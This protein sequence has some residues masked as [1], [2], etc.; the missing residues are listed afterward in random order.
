M[1]LCNSPDIFQE[2]MYEL[3]SDLEY[4]RAY[5]DDLLVTSCSTFEEHLQKLDEVFSR[6]SDAGLKVN[7]K[8]SHF[9][10]AEVE[11]LGYWI[12]RH[13]IQP[14]PNKVQAI[15]NIAPPKTRKQLRRFIGMVNYYRDM[16]V[17]RSEILAPLTRLSSEKV[18]FRWTDIEQ[19]AFE[20]IKTIVGR[21][22]LLSYPD[23]SQPFHIHTDASKTQLGSVISQDKKPIAFYSRKLQPAQTRYTTTERE[24]LSIVETLKEFTNILLGQKIIV[25]TDHKNLTCKNFNT[26]RVMRW[27]LILEEYGPEIKYIKGPKN[28]V[29]DAL[30]RLDINDEA[31]E[32]IPV[33]CY[34]LK[35]D[36]L[37]IDSFPVTYYL[38]NREQTKDQKLL[39]RAQKEKHFSLKVFH[40]GGKSTRL[41]CFK[42]KIVVPKGLQSQVIDF[43]HTRLCHPGINRTEETISQHFYWQ[44]MQND[45]TKAVSTCAICQKQKKQTKKY[46]LLPEKE[47]EYLPWDRLCVDLIGPYNIK[48]NVKGIA[49]PTLQCVTMIDPA[50]GW[51]EIAQYDN[52]KA[53]TVANIVEQQWLT[54][55][56]CPY[57]IT[58][59]R[60]SEFIGQDFREMCENDYGIKRKVIS[61]RNPQAN[62]VVERVHQTIGNLI[63]SF[64]L[65]DNP[66]IDEDDP[67][68][69]ILAATAFAVRSTYHTALRATP[70][71][72]VFGRDMILN[73]QHIADW[74]AIK[75]YKQNLIRKNNRI[76]NLKR[77]PYNY[78]VGDQVMI[79]NHRANKYEQP[80]KGPY[81]I[82][83]VN[84]NGTVRLK[85][86][87]VT[88]TVNIR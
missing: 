77:I 78:R 76:E 44:N 83:Q 50:T 11:Y 61:T 57:L 49:I 5:I 69:G 52:K 19:T 16:W 32:L 48:S 15:Q 1:G 59:D 9:A 84:T 85:M 67:W 65:Q 55:Y 8:K 38:L 33:D 25:H 13:G 58:L 54:R 73:V 27:R 56:P 64:E 2:R 28:I 87:A 10:Q 43:Y 35:K 23:F 14:L 31:F 7:A 66:Y 21:E 24:L 60:G 71:Q 62:A 88:D 51:F 18:E 6:L 30:S 39:E 22:V 42:E 26:E 80:Y 46:G 36:D 47:A 37:P 74:T 4:V 40:G 34:G 12:T 81:L 75:A 70:G 45:I 3:F 82:Q 20:T 68:S 29:A 63:R 86:G 41:L 72:L 17:H 53:I 79:E